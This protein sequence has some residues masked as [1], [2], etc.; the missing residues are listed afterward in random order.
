[1][2]NKILIEPTFGYTN[3]DNS[4]RRPMPHEILIEWVDSVN[5]IK[6]RNRLLIALNFC[7]HFATMLFMI[8]YF[9]FC[10]SLGSFFFM[11]FMIFF[12]AIVYNTLWF[13]RYCCHAAFKF[14]K[15]AY[16]LFLLWTNPFV[17]REESYA[18]AHLVHHQL[19]DKAGDPY[20]PHLGCFG[21]YFAIESTQKLNTNISNEDFEV[22]KGDIEHIGFKMNTYEQ[23]KKT[24]CVENVYYYLCRITFAQLLWGLFSF[25]IGG[26]RFLIAWYSALFIITFLIRDFNWRGHGGNYRRNK[27]PGW[28]FDKTSAL[29]QHF[30]GYLASE[31]HDN[32]HRYPMS[33][34]TGFLPGQIDIAF[35]LIWSLAKLN[36]VHYHFNAAVNFE[37][38][39]NKE[40]EAGQNNY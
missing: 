11:I 17:F 30:Y 34:N 1:M 2:N 23:F 15:R 16:A 13:H 8:Y 22:L 29:N 27:K 25:L 31:W 18:L 39:V 38:K 26:F 3:L 4:P 20:G 37:T 35:W 36:V 7:F 40:M 5:F 21:S 28:E 12:L 14:K 33:V 19:T 10:F 6:S 32:H 24:G 9:S